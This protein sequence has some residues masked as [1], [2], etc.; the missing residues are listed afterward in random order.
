MRRFICRL[1]KLEELKKDE[2]RIAR[3][4][5]KK[6]REE[7]RSEKQSF[8]ILKTDQKSYKAQL[9]E[10]GLDLLNLH[11]FSWYEEYLEIL[12][13]KIKDKKESLL[14]WRIYL[15][16]LQKI[17]RKREKE[18]KVLEKFRH[19]K[20]AL[21]S[22]ELKKDEQKELDEINRSLNSKKA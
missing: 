18:K 13:A 19:K 16:Q 17:A 14:R 7:L 6:A 20:F 8:N 1:E 10:K 21:F 2:L 4:A 5:L 12:R 11:E 9:R 22:G 3:V 15:R